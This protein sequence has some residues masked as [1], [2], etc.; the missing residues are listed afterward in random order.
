MTK[1]R[2]WCFTVF[3]DEEV[4]EAEASVKFSEINRR[5]LNAN[6]RVK[7]Y[8]SALERAP[9]TNRLHIHL[10]VYCYNSCKK[11]GLLTLMEVPAETH[12]E[13]AL[14]N[15]FQNL[16]YCSKED[17][18]QKFKS[19]DFPDQKE[20]KER[21]KPQVFKKAIAAIKKNPVSSVVN[22]LP[23]VLPYINMLTS[24][25]VT[26]ESEAV[27]TYAYMGNLMSKNIII[28]GPTASG[29]SSNILASCR[30]INWK[31]DFKVQNKWFN[32]EY[33]TGDSIWH[34]CEDISL[35]FFN[36]FETNIKQW[37]DHYPIS[38]EFK[39]GTGLLNPI[40]RWSFTTN[41]SLDDI[42]ANLRWAQNEANKKAFIRRFLWVQLYPEDSF[43]AELEDG[44]TVD[45]ENQ[46]INTTPARLPFVIARWL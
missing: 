20:K 16:K 8:C 2:A 30:N 35:D 44:T 29:K 25:K 22:S 33:I 3:L 42:I 40:S 37:T 13:K 9:S 31:P 18:I 15:C 45:Q 7:Y 6:S 19:P 14:G 5:L 1:S 23:T 28:S 32:P 24:L 41:H 26:E 38:V 4:G 27:K 39:G 10:Y 34:I 46:R 36:E 12:A 43:V 11:D 17:A 21:S